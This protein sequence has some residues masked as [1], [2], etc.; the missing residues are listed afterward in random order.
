MTKYDLYR[1]K[2]PEWYIYM[3]DEDEFPQLTEAA[4]PEARESFARYLEEKKRHKERREAL[5]AELEAKQRE[6]RDNRRPPMRIS[7]NQGALLRGRLYIKKAGDVQ[8]A[9]ADAWRFTSETKNARS[10]AVDA[11]SFTNAIIAQAGGNYLNSL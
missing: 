3:N 6:K 1:M 11:K 10:P 2:D 9:D 5:A 4:P 7:P 8:T